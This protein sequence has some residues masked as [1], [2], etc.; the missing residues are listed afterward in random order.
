MLLTNAISNKKYK[1]WAFCENI[2]IKRLIF[3]TIVSHMSLLR[4]S[5]PRILRKGSHCAKLNV[6]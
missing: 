3:R 6:L 1:N 4:I 2:P 5:S